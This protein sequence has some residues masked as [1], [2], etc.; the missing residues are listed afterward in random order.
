[1]LRIGIVLKRAMLMETEEPAKGRQALLHIHLL[2]QEACM[3][4]PYAKTG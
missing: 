4:G 1:M 3:Y 2:A